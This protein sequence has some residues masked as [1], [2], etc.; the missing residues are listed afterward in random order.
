MPTRPGNYSFHFFGTIKG[1]PYDQTFQSGEETFDAP[2]NPADVSFPAKDPT[3]GELAARVD[4]LSR[5]DASTSP[6]NTGMIGIGLA[7]LA[8][9]VAAAAF[10]KKSKAA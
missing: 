3:A 4:Q 5:D 8:L 9:I 2:K 1:Q 10:V 6:D 7:V